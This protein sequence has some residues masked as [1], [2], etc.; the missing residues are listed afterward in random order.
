MKTD[1]DGIHIYHEDICKSHQ[2]FDSKHLDNLY[3]AENRLFWSIARKEYILGRFNTYVP[4]SSDVIEIGAGTGNVSRML[5]SE[6]FS[7]ISVGEMHLNGLK[8]AKTYGIE[9]CYQ[10][11]LLRSPFSSRFDTVCMFDVLEHIENDNL[12]LRNCHKMLRAGGCV[13]ITVPSHMLLWNRS[14]R[15]VGHKRRYSKSELKDKMLAAGFEIVEINYFFIL[16]TPFLL[17]RK[18]LDLDDGSE[19]RNDEKF[20]HMHLNKFLNKVLLGISRLEH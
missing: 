5:L 6:G 19:V 20:K 17:L 18:L 11:D 14:D 13:I 16:L 10:F 3:S 12:A 1:S 7:N 4:R 15:V 9:N 2:D 8:Y